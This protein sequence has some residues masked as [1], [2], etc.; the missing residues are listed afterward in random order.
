MKK[1][2]VLLLSVITIVC[3]FA[4]TGCGISKSAE[5]CYNVSI[6]KKMYTQKENGE[7]VY[8]GLKLDKA[9]QVLKSQIFEID[10]YEEIEEDG[11]K[12]T[13]KYLYNFSSG[14]YQVVEGNKLQVLPSEDTTVVY[15][16]R[17]KKDI[18]IYY[19]NNKVVSK[20]SG[21]A[22]EEYNEYFIDTYNEDFTITGY[23]L[24]EVLT[25]EY[26]VT[27]ELYTN[28]DFTG[29]PF[30]SEDFSY[31]SYYGFS[32]SL[33]FKMLETTDVYVKVKKL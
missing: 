29:D 14:T 20:L 15:R 24:D 9:F 27:L 17:E 25:E 4:L 21:D 22:K 23:Q 2:I 33:S 28:P 11:V 10:K 32:G 12:K 7:V 1:L 30:A 3:T 31:S 5:N 16:E 8:N 18:N 13:G 26:S 6:Y 19:K